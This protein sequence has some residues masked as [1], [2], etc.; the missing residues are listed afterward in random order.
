MIDTQE[1]PVQGEDARYVEIQ[2]VRYFSTDLP[3]PGTL[4]TV[5]T[6]EGIDDCP[7]ANI[8]FSAE[9]PCGMALISAVKGEWL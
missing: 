5:D 9:T 7:W 8:S 6:Y 1:V 3:E 4:V 2:G